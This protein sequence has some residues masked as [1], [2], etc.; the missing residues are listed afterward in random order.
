MAI[1]KFIANL[2]DDVIE[3]YR[4]TIS[5]K[6]VKDENSPF[7]KRVRP[8]VTSRSPLSRSRRR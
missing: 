4:H 5:T 3:K 6:E 1:N 8:S 2:K 7:Y